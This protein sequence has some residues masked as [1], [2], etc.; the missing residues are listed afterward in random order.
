[1]GRSCTT[2]SLISPGTMGTSLVWSWAISQGV[3]LASSRARC[4]ALQPAGGQRVDGV[5]VGLAH[6]HPPAGVVLVDG[7]VEGDARRPGDLQVV[8]QRRG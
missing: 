1:M 5:G 7:G 6:F 4:D 8:G 2:Y 3:V